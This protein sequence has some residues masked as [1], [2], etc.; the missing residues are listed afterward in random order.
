M[1]PLLI[2]ISISAYL[3]TGALAMQSWLRAR[4]RR[5]E[6]AFQHLSIQETALRAAG[7]HV[8]RA[9]KREWNHD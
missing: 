4:R 6:S 7:C 1:R 8:I 2:T 3:R 9:K 5:Q